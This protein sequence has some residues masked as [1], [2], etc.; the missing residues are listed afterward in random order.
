MF[1]TKHL[2]LEADGLAP[3]QSEVR[4]L[5]EIRA[6]GMAHFSLPPGKISTAVTHRTVEELWY[7]L[8][9]HGR[10]WRLQGDQEE[11]VT[12][13]PDLCL[14]VPLG[15]HFQFRND[16]EDEL[17]IIIATIPT[18]PGPSEAVEVSGRWDVEE[19]AT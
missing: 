12:L 13:E 17:E 18:W 6:A 1:D 5:L 10:M 19:D 14:S 7:I 9:G 15:T 11:I 4:L 2:P 8:A 3:D 16:G